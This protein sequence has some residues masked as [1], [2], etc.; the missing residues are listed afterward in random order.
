MYVLGKIYKRTLKRAMN[1]W[2]HL[3]SPFTDLY[4]T[5][6]GGSLYWESVTALKICS[7]PAVFVT[8]REY[9]R[10]WAVWIGQYPQN[11]RNTPETIFDRFG[12]FESSS[13]N[14]RLERCTD[15]SSESQSPP[16]GG[17]RATNTTSPSAAS[18]HSSPD[19]LKNKRDSG[20]QNGEDEERPPRKYRTQGGFGS[21]LQSSY[22]FACHFHKF[23]PTKYSTQSDIKYQMC[24]GPGWESIATVK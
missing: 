9:G 20:D 11:R 22:R 3:D 18:S 19:S 12:P 24:M 21:C 14:R 5:L 1:K 6:Q 4:A 16:S 8:I 23:S 17:N 10:N 7:A 2:N 15:K 13:M